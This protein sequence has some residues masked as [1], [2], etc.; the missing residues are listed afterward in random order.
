MCCIYIVAA[1]PVGRGIDDGRVHMKQNVTTLL[2]VYCV[3][4]ASIK[5]IVWSVTVVDDRSFE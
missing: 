4:F 3:C 5:L 2:L 1:K